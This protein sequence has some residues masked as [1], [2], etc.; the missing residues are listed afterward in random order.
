MKCIQEDRIILKLG[1]DRKSVYATKCCFKPEEVCGGLS[2]D[3]IKEKSKEVVWKSNDENIPDLKWSIVDWCK[4]IFDKPIENHSDTVFPQCK[5][6]MGKC[7]MSK[8]EFRTVAVNI[9]HAC[10]LRCK[11][12]FYDKVNSPEIQDAYFKILHSLSKVDVDVALTEEGEPFLDKERLLYALSK[13]SSSP[14]RDKAIFITTNATLLD[15]MYID[16]LHWQA[17]TTGVYY[18]FVISC[19]GITPDTYKTI[20]GINKFYTVIENIKQIRKWGKEDNW[21]NIDGIN[22]VAQPDN[23]HEIR[24]VKRFFENLAPGLGEKVNIIPFQAD[25]NHPETKEIE[26]QVLNSPEWQDYI[27]SLN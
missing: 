10:N 23:L 8:M 21:I 6:S 14:D 1:K 20:R 3:E 7:D 24:N 19:D 16:I 25:A 26:E 2:F 22:F 17:K 5:C 13:F 15:A 11:H 9:S 27:N 12:C 18:S 4:D